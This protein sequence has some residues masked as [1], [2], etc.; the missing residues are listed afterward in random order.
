[1]E[2]EIYQISWG[3]YHTHLQGLGPKCEFYTRR[4][5]VFES[6]EKAINKANEFRKC[7]VSD[8]FVI[9]PSLKETI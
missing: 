4:A 9:V 8:T 6:V 5:G 2:H 1:M 3:I 7:F